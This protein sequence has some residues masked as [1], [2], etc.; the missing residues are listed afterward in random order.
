MITKNIVL[1][2]RNVYLKPFTELVG[3]MNTLALP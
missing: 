2:S 1:I 3:F